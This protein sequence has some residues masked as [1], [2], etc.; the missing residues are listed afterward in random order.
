M[1]QLREMRRS[2]REKVKEDLIFDYVLF[3]QIYTRRRRRL[4]RLL[5]TH[6]FIF[7]FLA[8]SANL[9]RRCQTKLCGFPV[10]T[11]YLGSAQAAPRELACKPSLASGEA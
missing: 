4:T 11:R 9:L 10:K 7:Y 5:L 8:L 2:G 6:L 3:A 1:A